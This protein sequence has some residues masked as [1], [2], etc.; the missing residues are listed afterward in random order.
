M[1]KIARFVK[2]DIVTAIPFM[3][4][5]FSIGFLVLSVIIGFI[6]C[7]GYA[8]CSTFIIV[9]T[10]LSIHFVGLPFAAGAKNNLYAMY[11]LLGIKRRTV[12]LGR[13]IFTLVSILVF[14]IVGIG[15]S[16]GLAA[17]H[18]APIAL[19]MVSVLIKSALAFLGFSMGQAILIPYFFKHNYIKGSFITSVP[20]FMALPMMSFYYGVLEVLPNA[21]EFIATNPIIIVA[22]AFAVWVAAMAISFVLS[23]RVYTKRDF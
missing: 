2:L 8:V 22:P 3:G 10:M 16:I 6:C 11:S 7:R 23:L 13:Y 20:M 9:F 19:G 4:L 18:Q 15:L 5:K 17:I 12:V 21:R 1:T 14:C